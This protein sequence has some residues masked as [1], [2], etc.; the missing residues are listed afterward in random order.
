[1]GNQMKV[2]RYTDIFRMNE[3]PYNQDYLPFRFIS[4]LNVAG[5]WYDEEHD[6]HNFLLYFDK[7]SKH[8]PDKLM[9]NLPNY[10]HLHL[11]SIGDDYWSVES[12]KRKDMLT[13]FYRNSARLYLPWSSEWDYEHHVVNYCGDND[14]WHEY[15]KLMERW[16]SGNACDC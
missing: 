9:K 16:Q 6:Y 15:E 12:E 3:H 14:K 10:N 8:V 5:Y 13:Y 1:M 11:W 2:F 7:D 4:G